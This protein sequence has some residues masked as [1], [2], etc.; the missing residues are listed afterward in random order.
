MFAQ[1]CSKWG[2]LLVK[3]LQSSLLEITIW[4]NQPGV[5]VWGMGVRGQGV[6]QLFGG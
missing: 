5:T 2:K 6:R 4:D 3:D 1:I